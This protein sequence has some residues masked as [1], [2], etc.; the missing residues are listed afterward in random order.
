MDRFFSIRLIGDMNIAGEGN[1]RIQQQ[2]T[3]P[4]PAGLLSFEF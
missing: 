1:G 4:A 3:R 2:D